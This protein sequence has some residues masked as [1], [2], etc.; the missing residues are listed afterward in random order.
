MLAEE[1]RHALRVARK[2][3]DRYIEAVPLWVTFASALAFAIGGA[4]GYRRIVETIGSKIGKSPLDAVQATATQVSA[5]ACMALADAIGAPVSTT[6][7]VSS[8]VAGSMVASRAGVRFGIARNIVVVWIVTLPAT[9]AI[10]YVLSLAA[11][12]LLA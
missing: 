5:V 9:M 8:G 10:A 12:R 1:D 7:L 4:I 6:H 2:A 3:L 11:H